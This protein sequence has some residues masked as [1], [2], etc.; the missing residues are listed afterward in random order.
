MLVFKRVHA[1][2]NWLCSSNVPFMGDFGD[3]EY[4][5]FEDVPFDQYGVSNLAVS[6]AVP[7]Y[8]TGQTIRV[9]LGATNGT[10]VG[11]LTTRS[12]SPD[13]DNWDEWYTFA[14]Q[15]ISLSQSIAGTTSIYFVGESL[16]GDIANVLRFRFYRDPANTREVIWTF[17]DSYFMTNDL[18][19]LK[20]LGYNCIRL[21][22]F[23]HLL[24][25]DL[26]PYTYKTSGWAR[27]DWVLDECAKRS[28]YCLLDLH[29]AAG[30]VNPWHSAGER[31]PLRNRLW[32]ND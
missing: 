21:P 24:E 17:Q 29:G 1:E 18:D 30:G 4:L 25:N 9:F 27:L 19:R 15:H 12:T 8:S 28:M 13:L 23:Y 11:T 10:L 26:N 6:I 5:G 16:G 22:F 2:V 3:G 20:S 31:M 32:K 7:E 14:E